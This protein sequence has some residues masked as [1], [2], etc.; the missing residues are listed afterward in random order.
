MGK[1]LYLPG[2]DIPS[3]FLQEGVEAKDNT[4]DTMFYPG[5][6]GAREVVGNHHPIF[7]SLPY[8]QEKQPPFVRR[9]IITEAG[10]DSWESRS[11]GVQSKLALKAAKLRDLAA[12]NNVSRIHTLIQQTKKE[13]LRDLF[14]RKTLKNR[15]TPAIQ[16][17]FERFCRL[18]KGH[19]KLT[20]LKIVRAS[21]NHVE[22]GRLLGH[23]QR[24]G[25]HRF[26]AT[27]SPG[28][29]TGLYKLL[30]KKDGREPKTFRYPCAAPLRKGDGYVA[31][32]QGKC[33]L[34][35]DYFMEKFTEPVE[36]PAS[37]GVETTQNDVGLQ[38]GAKRKRERQRETSQMG[39][40]TQEHN[41]E[42]T[43]ATMPFLPFRQVEMMK[44]LRSM[45]KGKAPGADALPSE[46]YQR[47]P[48]ALWAL[49]L[50]ASTVIRSGELPRGLQEVRIVPLD[51]PGKD[52]HLCESKRPISL[53]QTFVRAIEIMVYNRIIRTTERQIDP[54]QFAY[55]R[56]RG[57]ETQMALMSHFI[58]TK[59]DTGAYVYIASLDIKGAFDTVPHNGLVETLRRVPMDPHCR[60]FIDHWVRSRKFR[61]QLMTPQGRELSGLRPITRG[62]PQ[63]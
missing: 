48:G 59:L 38:A 12:G 47:L 27:I 24:D 28:N 39:A 46:V 37:Q 16:D 60:R 6:T 14:T 1:F 57:A 10:D 8:G 9:L 58:T 26:L 29:T 62:L 7:L 44:A 15:K 43:Q 63:G 17:P 21:G 35:A 45:A 33:G 3:T 49:T 34:L 11:E 20:E 40:R 18:N 54:T 52:P 5:E 19:P 56:A 30:R 50:L 13:A 55:R 53:I 61:V 31:R 36:T 2:E 4:G 25:W 41:E 22:E 23:I 32:A 51:K 42:P